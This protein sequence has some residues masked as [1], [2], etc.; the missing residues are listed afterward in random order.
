MLRAE[1][2]DKESFKE[3]YQ[4]NNKF[5]GQKNLRCYPTCSVSG[6]R[7]SGFCGTSLTCIVQ[8]LPVLDAETE[9]RA[10]GEFIICGTK[11][12]MRP[13]TTLPLAEAQAKERTAALPKLPWLAGDVR[14]QDDNSFSIAFNRQLGGWHYGWRA[15]K[16]SCDSY[17][18]FRAYIFKLKADS[19][20]LVYVG[21]VSSPVFQVYSRRRQRGVLKEEAADASTNGDDVPI[22]PP[23]AKR[24]KVEAPK[25]PS[26]ATLDSNSSMTMPLRELASAAMD[27]K[28]LDTLMD[29][30]PRQNM[31][32][33]T[34]DR[35]TYF[36]FQFASGNEGCWDDTDRT[37]DVS[38]EVTNNNGPVH[39]L[40]DS[41]S[42]TAAGGISQGLEMDVS[43]AFSGPQYVDPHLWDPAYTGKP[44]VNNNYN[45]INN[46]GSGGRSKN[47]NI[48]INGMPVPPLPHTSMGEE[49]R[50]GA[51]VARSVPNV[52]L[53]FLKRGFTPSNPAAENPPS[54]V[55]NMS[56]GMQQLREI[57]M[58]ESSYAHDPQRID[59]IIEGVES[60]SECVIRLAKNNKAFNDIV[61]SYS[62]P[63]GIKRLKAQIERERNVNFVWSAE[64]EDRTY[65][66]TKVDDPDHE[67]SIYG[68]LRQAFRNIMMSAI[69]NTG[70]R[71]EPYI[72]SMDLAARHGVATPDPYYPPSPRAAAFIHMQLY[73]SL[74]HFEKQDYGSREGKFVDNTQRCQYA[75]DL[76]VVRRGIMRRIVCNRIVSD[77]RTRAQSSARDLEPP[78]APGWDING[79]WILLGPVD[80]P[81][82][83]QGSE[84]I[85]ALLSICAGVNVGGFY[86]RVFTT[87]LSKIEVHITEE[88]FTSRGQQMLLADP[89]LVANLKGK[90][91]CWRP[92]MPMVV[93]YAGVHPLSQNKLIVGW[94]SVEKDGQH[95]INVVI[96]GPLFA[97]AVSELACDTIRR[98]DGEPNTAS[99]QRLS[100]FFQQHVKPG[101]VPQ[102]R[103]HKRFIISHSRQ[104]LTMEDYF[105]IFPR[106]A[107]AP[108]MDK[109]SELQTLTGTQDYKFTGVKMRHKFMRCYLNQTDTDL[110]LDLL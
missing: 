56:E 72:E 20:D 41:G 95:C 25:A 69:V 70:Q 67:T 55:T 60:I 104:H 89:R 52:D 109:T 110:I 85:G 1:W 21:S 32:N 18:C 78:V 63:E 36:I 96:G 27:S 77:Q 107:L 30:Y 103:I 105:H 48:T 12:L 82:F 24:A 64:R 35:L 3:R 92:S 99:A 34:L 98:R 31:L 94:L 33:R 86:N 68:M 61:A 51:G 57:L 54:N 81:G 19:P 75:K 22:P 80:E 106:A 2:V 17:H 79:T 102:L 8:D 74:D 100:K 44:S 108:R 7:D 46:D 28:I 4:R 49:A 38:N 39:G 5:G 59:M 76:M 88:T 87:M 11:E 53:G 42:P 45:D 83:K 16:H 50:G 43:E 62:S 29:N 97:E 93:G 37:T 101:D 47:S 26:M 90:P 84:G 58:R 9:Y 40:M 91:H 6:H 73:G 23:A 66:P 14:L 13:N 15:N 71:L 65:D 10:Y